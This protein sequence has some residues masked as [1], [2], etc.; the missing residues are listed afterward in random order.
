MTTIIEAI[1]ENGVLK[2]THP[3]P[4]PDESHVFVT[5][6]TNAPSNED[7]RTAWLNHSAQQLERAWEIPADDVFNELLEK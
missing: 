7:E 1:Y 4:L 3:L 5:I 2:L 6:T